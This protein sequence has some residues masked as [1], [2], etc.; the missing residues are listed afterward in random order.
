MLLSVHEVSVSRATGRSNA[1]PLIDTCKWTKGWELDRFRC[2]IAIHPN[3][4][5]FRYGMKPTRSS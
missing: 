5:Q 3:R 1:T 4:V 2:F